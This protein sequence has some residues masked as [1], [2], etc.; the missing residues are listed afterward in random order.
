MPKNKVKKKI[1]G[2]AFERI[3][4]LAQR[5]DAAHQAAKEQVETAHRE[6]WN[7]IYDETGLSPIDKYTFDHSNEDL[8]FYIVK[9]VEDGGPCDDASGRPIAALSKLTH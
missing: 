2:V 3:R 4:D 1:D 5:L 6:F 9:S 7:A 8:G